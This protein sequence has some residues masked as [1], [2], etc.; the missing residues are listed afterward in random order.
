MK[1][2]GTCLG[3]TKCNNIYFLQKY[4]NKILTILLNKYVS[5]ILD[6][7]LD[8]KRIIFTYDVVC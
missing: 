4:I 7:K 5:L 3:V 8:L 1:V 2:V 6:K